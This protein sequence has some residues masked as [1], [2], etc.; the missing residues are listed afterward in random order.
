MSSS[1]E[2]LMTPL[3]TLFHISI[4]NSLSQTPTGQIS[5]NSSHTLAVASKSQTTTTIF[6]FYPAYPFTAT[7]NA[8]SLYNIQRQRASPVLGIPC[9]GHSLYRGSALSKGCFALIIIPFC[10]PVTVATASWRACLYIVDMH[11]Q[12][13]LFWSCTAWGKEGTGVSE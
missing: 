8:T 4:E 5:T 2:I 12:G 7:T 3:S 10:I 9:S 1:E 6:D 13:A 11:L